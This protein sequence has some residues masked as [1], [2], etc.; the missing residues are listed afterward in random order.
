MRSTF[1]SLSPPE[2]DLLRAMTEVTDVP[3]PF[4]IAPSKFREVQV[5]IK[6]ELE[7]SPALLQRPFVALAKA[8]DRA[9]KG[10]SLHNETDVSR[11]SEAMRSLRIF[12]LH[13]SELL[14]SIFILCR[15]LVDYELMLNGRSA[16]IIYR[17]VLTRLKEIPSYVGSWAISSH[18]GLS[19]VW[20][21]ALES[22]LRRRVPAFPPSFMNE[23]DDNVY[24]DGFTGVARTLLP[25]IYES[26]R[27]RALSNANTVDFGQIGQDITAWRPVYPAEGLSAA[28]IVL[29][30]THANMYKL[31]LLLI[32]KQYQNAGPAET[33]DAIDILQYAKLC[34]Q[35]VGYIPP[36]TMVPLFVAGLEL[37]DEDMRV[38]LLKYMASTPGAFKHIPYIR[39]IEF[40]KHFW[41]YR[42]EN[43]EADWLKL[44]NELPA[45]NITP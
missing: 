3:S 36:Y 35:D 42:K 45:F 37:E 11:I 15:C 8:R 34:I 33:A 18:D 20:M 30:R 38:E 21:D 10:Q 32:V 2:I 1:M 23:H 13:K 24:V 26:C 16:H 22:L 31:A 19:L 44:L 17:N 43:N 6:T 29:L 9:M 5:S 28:E 41:S 7:R 40:M 12:D 39:M 27:L 25:L 4:A 14:A